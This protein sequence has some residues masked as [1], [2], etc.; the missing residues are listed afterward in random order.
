[1]DTATSERLAT[2]PTRSKTIAIMS[3]TRLM[4]R[5]LRTVLFRVCP[6]A[7]WSHSKAKFWSFRPCSPGPRPSRWAGY[8]GSSTQ[9]NWL[10]ELNRHCRPSC[11]AGPGEKRRGCR[12]YRR[13]VLRSCPWRPRTRRAAHYRHSE[14][15]PR[16][17]F[18]EYLR[19][20]LHVTFRYL[21]GKPGLGAQSSL[22]FVS[23]NPKAFRLQT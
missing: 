5:S 3:S 2:S 18:W 20:V 17:K 15:R 12:R 8:P 9:N 21:F 6:S 4:P 16:R 10:R 13:A 1:M 7:I 22:P 14:C 23:G 11:R 19:L